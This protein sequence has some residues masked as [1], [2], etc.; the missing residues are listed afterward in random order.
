VFTNNNINQ[1]CGF[2]IKQKII[3]KLE[4]G[5]LALCKQESSI[6]SILNEIKKWIKQAV[7]D[8]NI[9][10]VMVMKLDDMTSPICNSARPFRLS[11]CPFVCLSVH[12]AR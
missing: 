9:K 4:Q 2:K 10:P 6:Q 12:Q 7:S 1:K 11:L 8:I 3:I 5:K